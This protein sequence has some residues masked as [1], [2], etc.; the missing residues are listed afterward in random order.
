MVLHYHDGTV[1]LYFWLFILL[2]RFFLQNCIHIIQLITK[3]VHIDGLHLFK[4]FVLHQT[5]SIPPQPPPSKGWC[6]SSF[7]IIVAGVPGLSNSFFFISRKDFYAFLI[8]FI[9]IK[10]RFS[11]ALLNDFQTTCVEPKYSVSRQIQDV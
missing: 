5:P 10:Y 7:A 6:K 4:Q 3:C 11:H 8:I 9:I 2:S 1:F